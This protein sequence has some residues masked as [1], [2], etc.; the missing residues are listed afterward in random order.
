MVSIKRT[1]ARPRKSQ[2]GPASSSEGLDSEQANTLTTIAQKRKAA[3]SSSDSCSDAETRMLSYG[4]AK[5]EKLGGY[6]SRKIPRSKAFD[7]SVGLASERSR[8]QQRTDQRRKKV[9]RSLDTF[10]EREQQNI[11]CFESARIPSQLDQFCSVQHDRH[12][13]TDALTTSVTKAFNLNA[14]ETASY[15]PSSSP[16]SSLSSLPTSPLSSSPVPVWSS[17]VT[18]KPSPCTSITRKAALQ[19]SIEAEVP[20]TL[21]STDAGIIDLCVPTEQSAIVCKNSSIQTPTSPKRTLLITRSSLTP[22]PSTPP[23]P[24][25]NSSLSS[26]RSPSTSPYKPLISGTAF[27][28][29]PPSPPPP[30][31]ETLLPLIK[32]SLLGIAGRAT[33]RNS[34][35]KRS[36]S[37][38]STQTH[39]SSLSMSRC[40]SGSILT[41][42]A[43]YPPSPGL[44]TQ[45]LQAENHDNNGTKCVTT[46]MSS[47]SKSKRRLSSK[48]ASVGRS[49][50]MLQ[51]F[52]PGIV[53]EPRSP[54]VRTYGRMR[55]Y[56][57]SAT[58]ESQPQR[59]VSSEASKIAGQVRSEFAPEAWPEASSRLTQNITSESSE[60]HL[61]YTA[62]LERYGSPDHDEGLEVQTA[63]APLTEIRALAS[64]KKK[65]DDIQYLLQ[66]MAADKTG[67][68]L[69]SLL[70]I[71][72][73]LQ[74]RSWITDQSDVECCL[75]PLWGAACKAVQSHPTDEACSTFEKIRSSLTF[76]AAIEDRP[77][78]FLATCRAKAR[79]DTFR[80]G[81][82]F[83][84]SRLGFAKRNEAC[85]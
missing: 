5:F 80:E 49:P 22:L 14:E 16:L 54:S 66:G 76:F 25:S 35:Q 78:G 27:P 57:T 53:D 30:A 58:S 60:K 83:Q 56:I 32:P 46:P 1:Y 68:R 65:L 17:P 45:L 13:Q 64:K 37:D 2:F 6:A 77:S 18:K 81:L 43:M 23:R 71:F 69:A 20:Q 47:I 62:L 19:S 3:S 15:L 10:K 67:P 48:K 4:Q 36:D 73:L 50:G 44:A 34:M 74:S 24:A 52:S 85:L 70:E 29:P 55:S 75:T 28:S 42:P 8:N 84:T 79:L 11:T 38:K 61:P 9:P 39:G 51:P 72:D 21:A 12:D 40:N 59:A 26:V 63:I 31:L 41:V 7:M 82:Y 33:V